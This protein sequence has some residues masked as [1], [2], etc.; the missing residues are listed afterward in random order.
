M[1]KTKIIPL[2]RWGSLYVNSVL[3]AGGLRVNYL[4]NDFDIVERFGLNS[5]NAREPLTS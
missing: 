5:V 2:K 4:Q 1:L 3:K